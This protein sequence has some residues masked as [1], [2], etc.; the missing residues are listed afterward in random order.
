MVTE[1]MLKNLP[2]DPGVY[3]MKDKTGKVI[4]VGKAKI[5]K[6]RVRQYFQNTQ[7]HSPKVSAMVSRIDTFEYILTDSELEALILECNLIKKFRPYYNI[8]LKDDKNYPYIKVTTNEDYPRLKFVRRMQKDG[9]KYFGPY[10]SGAAVREAID[11]TCKLFKIPS[12]EIKLPK[13]LGKKRA[14]INSQIGRCCAPCENIITKEE[15]NKRIKAACEFLDGGASKLIGEL[16][17]EMNRLSENLEFERAASIRDEINGI[18]QVEKK[19]KI[20]SDKRAD[21]DVI[22][23][24]SQNN[25]TFCEV[26]FIRSGRL[27]GRHNVIMNNTSDMSESEIAESFVKQFYEDADFIPKNI[28]IQYECDENELLSSWLSEIS[29]RCVKIHTPK[30]SDKKAL[31][32]MANKNAKQSALNFMLKNADGQKGIKRLI[33]DLKEEL[34]LDKPPY[35]I[36]S[37]DISNISGTDNVGSM[38]VFVNGEPK[39]KFYRRFKIET[40]QGGDDYQSMSEMI[41][42]RLM[43]ANEEEKLIEKGELLREDAKFLP[44]PDCIFLDGGK[45]HLTVISE[46]LE[47]ADSEIP[48]FAMVKDDKHK[49]GALLRQDGS[50]VDLKPRSEEFRLVSHIQEEVH[51][52]AIE[53]HK[54]LRDKKV[55]KSSLQDIDGVGEKSA[56]K[57]LKYFKSLKA[58]KG[59]SVEELKRAGLNSKTAEKVYIYFKNKT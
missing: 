52:F 35:R 40:A 7:K 31:V 46:L 48:L 14:C 10:S 6:N 25:K 30:R 2:N 19:Q 18:R 53:Y 21:E 45:G 57:L 16:T 54:T 47:L 20:V 38:V 5:L 39:K 56:R 43:R 13:D 27:I 26:F 23:F 59:A 29:G 17:E 1:E 44:L 15:Y 22:G 24:Y 12:C 51:R 42:R 33:L 50:R 36:E 4:Y 34:G 55:K 37:Y 41:L 58:I 3:I 32:D 28:Y 11:L 8:L 9:A 49:T